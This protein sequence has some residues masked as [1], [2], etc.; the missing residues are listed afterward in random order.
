M[1]A[2]SAC[3]ASNSERALVDPAK[4]VIGNPRS[5]R[6]ILAPFSLALLLLLSPEMALTLLVTILIV[7][8]VKKE[9]V[10][11]GLSD[12]LISHNCFSEISGQK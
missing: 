8:S 12:E 9:M 5:P 4:E 6:G 7:I 3:K 1:L 10:E 11:D 2:A